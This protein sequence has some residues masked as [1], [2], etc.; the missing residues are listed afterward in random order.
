MNL[1]VL[2]A[3]VVLL[4]VA[5]YVIL[6]QGFMLVRFPP[7]SGSGVPTAELLVL[8]FILFFVFDL[9]R[10]IGFALVA[11]LFPLVVWWVLGTVQALRGLEQHGIWALRDASHLTDSFFIWIGFVIA[12]SP[13]FFARFSGWLRTVLNIG[14]LY[15]LLFPFRETLAAYSPKISAPA[16]YSAP[17]FFNY[18][19]SSLIPLTG[20]MAW[21]IDRVRFLALPAVALAGMLIVYNVV[22]FQA[23][24]TYLQVIALLMMLVIL[25]PRDAARM[26][27]SMLIGVAM[28]ALLLASGLEISGR[29]GEKFSL[30]FL[31]EHFF[32]IWGEQGSGMVAS[33]AD[34]VWLRF[35]WWGKIWN[36]LTSNTGSFLFGLGYGIPLTDFRT[37]ENAIVREPHNSFISLFARQ[38]LIGFLAF[39]WVQL[40]LVRSWFSVYRKCERQGDLLWR[41]TLLIMATFFVLLFVFALGED[42]FEKPFN[43]IPYYLFWGVILR[44]E[45]EL[46]AGRTLFEKEQSPTRSAPR[47][48]TAPTGRPI[49]AHF[50]TSR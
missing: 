13:D 50:G 37:P 12:A 43:A 9:R 10:L 6:N 7:G 48:K 35:R 24:T 5:A 20:A 1:S 31:L 23:R 44:S 41:N 42:G 4:L 46:R 16:G 2:R 25:R 33:A 28:L 29:L 27:F 30:D 14:V 26:S 21:L 40:A 34:G 45:F 49:P 17:I 11:P 32:S 18:I 22:M 8:A 19:S 15:G 36:D 3:R 47:H 39:I 38:G